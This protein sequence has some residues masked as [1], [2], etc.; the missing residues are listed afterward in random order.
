MI[1]YFSS[2]TKYKYKY[3]EEDFLL[4]TNN[5]GGDTQKAMEFKKKK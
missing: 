4:N 1:E 5:I 3:F 2:P